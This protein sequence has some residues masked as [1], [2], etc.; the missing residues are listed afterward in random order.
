MTTDATDLST[1]NTERTDR[2]DH[3]LLEEVSAVS[4]EKA[5]ISHR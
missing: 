2:V 4:W 3:K 5:R 1:E